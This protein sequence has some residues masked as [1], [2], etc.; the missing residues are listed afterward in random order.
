MTTHDWYGIA[1]YCVVFVVHFY[2][3]ADG[4][5]KGYRLALKHVGDEHARDLRG[6]FRWE[7]PRT[8][9]EI[10]EKLMAE[11]LVDRGR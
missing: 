5:K 4:A 11:D 2:S 3:W 9:W 10:V 6:M 1:V 8:P 7:V